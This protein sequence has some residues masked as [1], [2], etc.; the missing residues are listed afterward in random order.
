MIA[1][2]ENLIN[3]LAKTARSIACGLGRR[4]RQPARMLRLAGRLGAP[5]RRESRLAPVVVRRSIAS[6]LPHARAAPA[7]VITLVQQHCSGGSPGSAGE[8][9]QRRPG[10]PSSELVRQAISHVSQVRNG[11]LAWTL[12]AHLRQGGLPLDSQDLAA[13]AVVL[14][15]Q[16]EPSEPGSYIRW[17][18]YCEVSYS[19][20]PGYFLDFLAVL[21]QAGAPFKS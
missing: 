5:L 16:L 18:A 21:A 10:L 7:Q 6:S 15:R 4:P 8:D 17:Y 9:L 12:Y 1:I 19:P 13:L 3:P 2:F 14:V 20:L 11:Y